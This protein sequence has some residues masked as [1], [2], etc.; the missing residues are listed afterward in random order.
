MTIVIKSPAYP[1]VCFNAIK[2]G[3]AF[4]YQDKLYIR[5]NV[6]AAHDSYNPNAICLN[7]VDRPSFDLD[8]FGGF[9]MV[10]P[11]DIEINILPAGSLS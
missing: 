3:K 2:V 8:I 9:T 6:T 10:T 7:N 11:V 1:T 4:K 5:V